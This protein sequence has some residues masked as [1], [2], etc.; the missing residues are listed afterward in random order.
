MTISPSDPSVTAT[1]TNN[2]VNLATASAVTNAFLSFT[3]TASTPSNTYT[4]TIVANTNPANASLVT[5]ITNIFTVSMAVAGPFNPLK[6]W[7]P[8]GANTNW[9]I[10]GNWSPSGAPGSSNDVQF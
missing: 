7:S 2:P 6:L 9:S 3:T 4:V 1:I 5:P 10:A 8:A